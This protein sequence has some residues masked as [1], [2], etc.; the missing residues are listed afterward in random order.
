MR[1][2]DY[3]NEEALDLLA[4]LMDYVAEILSDDKTM[5]VY[6]TEKKQTNF[7][8]YVIKHHKHTIIA[9]LARI[10]GTPVEE[11]ECDFFSLPSLVIEM[12]NNKM[13]TNLFTSQEQSTESQS[14]GPATENTTD[15]ENQ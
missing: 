7:I 10:D 6:K 12:F 8:K 1:L 5:E 15:A 3:K 2:S 9:M 4:D 13:I 11:F 14:S